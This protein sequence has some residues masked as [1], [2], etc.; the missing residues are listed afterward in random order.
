MIKTD[1]SEL[2]NYGASHDFFLKTQDGLP[3]NYSYIGA[4]YVQ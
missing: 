1:Y 4:S 3:Y 2:Y